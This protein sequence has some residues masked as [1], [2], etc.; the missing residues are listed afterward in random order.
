MRGRRSGRLSRP[1]RTCPPYA[2]AVR[3]VATR[4]DGR[5]TV[6]DEARHRPRTRADG[7]YLTNRDL[8]SSSVQRR[9]EE[10]IETHPD[11]PSPGGPRDGSSPGRPFGDV[12]AS[13][14]DRRPPSALAGDESQPRPRRSRLPE[15]FQPDVIVA[16]AIGGALGAPA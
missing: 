2:L 14:A 4:E 11:R 10:A 16:I 15:R 13:A 12:R 9:T 3:E 1:V 8:P 5:L 6:G 7:L